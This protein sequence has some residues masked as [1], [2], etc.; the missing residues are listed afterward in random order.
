[1]SREQY[2][3]NSGQFSSNQLRTLQRRISNWGVEQ[4]KMHQET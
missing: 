1:M 4:L 3:D 2:V